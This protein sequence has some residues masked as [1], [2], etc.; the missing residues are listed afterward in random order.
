MLRLAFP[1][2]DGNA[3]EWHASLPEDIKNSWNRLEK[4]VLVDY[5]HARPQ[6]I[7]PAR[8]FVERWSI[9]V[10]P[11]A[12]LQNINSPEDW[13]SQARERR[14][15]YQEV[16]D[17]SAP[18]W[19]LVETEKDIPAAALATGFESSG[20]VLYSARAWVEGSGLIVGKCGK[21]ISGM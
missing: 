9:N 15:M 4:A 3:L 7:S 5:P 14:R 13:L 18:C 10:P 2:F 6:T 20:E 11:S 16:R 1:C 8:I 17:N 12:S 19:F 21:H